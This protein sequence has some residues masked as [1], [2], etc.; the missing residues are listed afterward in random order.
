MFEVL[1]LNAGYQFRNR[2]VHAVR[3]VS[4]KVEQDDFFGIAGESGCGKTTLMLASLG[5]L[6][7]PGKVISGRVL[8]EGLNLLALS[9]DE[10]KKVR[11]KKV[12]LV[13]QSSMN[14]LNPVM[15]VKDQMADVLIRN[16]GFSKSDAYE[17]V[18]EKLKLVGITPDRMESYPHQLS[19]GMR[20]R[21]SSRWHS[22]S[23]RGSSSWTNPPPHSTSSFNDRSCSR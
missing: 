8:V 1:E 22:C 12:S 17:L 6:K 18:K 2:F 3:N 23:R 9:N 5:L 7:K 13:T 16:H 14:S 21:W 15:K 20:Q 11:W 19:G 4:F 10:L